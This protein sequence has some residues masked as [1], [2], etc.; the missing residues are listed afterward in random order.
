MKTGLCSKHLIFASIYFILIIFVP[1]TVVA[2]EPR[3]RVVYHVDFADPDRLGATL[4]SV[5]NM[6]NTYQES[7]EEYDVRIVFL[8]Q[9]I[10]FL[11]TDPLKGTPFAEDKKLKA[12][13][14]VLMERLISASEVQEVKL[15]L[16]NITR[17]AINLDQKKIMKGV[18]MVQS[19][20][21]RIAELQSKGFAYL[22]MQ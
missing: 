4:T 19:G 10:R 9:G 13:K 15:E 5:Y 17:E 3:A 7:L 6:V 11:T 18:K 14:K 12:Q 2:E 22:K 16:C 21:V 8:G 1:T 20:V